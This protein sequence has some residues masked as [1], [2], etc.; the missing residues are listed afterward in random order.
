MY[1]LDHLIIDKLFLES[2]NTLDFYKNNLVISIRATLIDIE[3]IE[4]V[5]LYFLD[6]VRFFLLL[7]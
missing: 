5:F 7:F 4:F 1:L 6:F 2:I 3:A